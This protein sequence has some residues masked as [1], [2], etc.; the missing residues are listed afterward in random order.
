MI[1]FVENLQDRIIPS[2]DRFANEHKKG[3]T[4]IVASKD[5]P[6]TEF[7]MEL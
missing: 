2:F 7:F 4:M 5:T 1:L 3:M 6:H